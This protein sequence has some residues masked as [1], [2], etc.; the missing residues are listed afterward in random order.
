[1]R[2]QMAEGWG[3]DLCHEKLSF[4]SAGISPSGV[5]PLAVETMKKVGIDISHHDSRGLDEN[6]LNWA[7]YIITMADSIQRY[8][9]YFPDSVTHIHWS[10]PN[11]DAMCGKDLS[12]KKAYEIVRELIKKKIDDF[13][14]N[15]L[16]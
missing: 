10:I 13:L 16:S 3:R 7:D 1:M 12:R 11:P 6:I 15:E 2:S 14:E 5:H 4:S 8:S 9:T